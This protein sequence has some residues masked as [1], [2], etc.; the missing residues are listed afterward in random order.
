MAEATHKTLQC[1]DRIEIAAATAAAAD[2]IVLREDML[3]GQ[4]VAQYMLE[5]SS[6]GSTW[7]NVTS[8][9]GQTIGSRVWDF[10]PEP[11]VVRRAR[12]TLLRCAFDSVFLRQFALFKS[13]PPA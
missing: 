1:G 12:L 6:D 9:N 11:T 7:R 4:S 13:H 2:L 5:I 3:Q 8:A 10:L